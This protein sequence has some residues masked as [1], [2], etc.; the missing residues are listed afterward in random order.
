MYEVYKMRKSRMFLSFCLKKI[1]LEELSCHLLRWGSLHEKWVF[2]WQMISILAMLVLR[3]LRDIKMKL[4]SRQL[5]IWAWSSGKNLAW[6]YKLRVIKYIDG[7]FDVS[8]TREYIWKKEVEN[9]SDYNWKKKSK[10][11]GEEKKSARR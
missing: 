5:D 3:C 10:Y 1:E 2:V 9:L 6:K 11:W 7:K 4:L 8:V